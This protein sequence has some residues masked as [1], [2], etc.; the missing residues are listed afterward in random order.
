MTVVKVET[1]ENAH[2]SMYQKQAHRSKENKN[3]F[4]KLISIIFI[5]LWIIQT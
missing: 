4:G 5:R 1:G 2:I 3:F